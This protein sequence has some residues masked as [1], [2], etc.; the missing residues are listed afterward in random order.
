MKLQVNPRSQRQSVPACIGCGNPMTLVRVE[1]FYVAAKGW[2]ETWSFE[3]ACGQSF[4]QWD[5][6]TQPVAFSAPD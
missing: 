3:C 6:G 1:P 4:S 2:R 5:A